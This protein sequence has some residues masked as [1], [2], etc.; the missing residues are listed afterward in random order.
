MESVGLSEVEEDVPGGESDEGEDAL[1]RGLGDGEGILDKASPRPKVRSM[2]QRMTSLRER[3][4]D[5]TLKTAESAKRRE[6]QRRETDAQR[7]R[8]VEDAVRERELQAAERRAQEDLRRKTAALNAQRAALAKKKK[9]PVP[10]K[11]AGEV[12]A[13]RKAAGESSDDYEMDE[14]SPTRQPAVGR[15]SRQRGSSSR[16]KRLVEPEYDADMEDDEP[17]PPKRPVAN[18][19]KTPPPRRP[20]REPEQ[21]AGELREDSD[22][23]EVAKS[24]KEK[25]V[26]RR[27]SLTE[28]LPTVPSARAEPKP[29]ARRGRPPKQ[30]PLLESAT[31]SPLK[32]RKHPDPTP[33][34]ASVKNKAG[35]VV[36]DVVIG[37]EDS[38]DPNDRMP[39][40]KRSPRRS[41]VAKGNRTGRTVAPVSAPKAKRVQ[42]NAN[43]SLKGG[44]K[45]EAKSDPATE[46][47]LEE[48]QAIDQLE[49]ENH[50]ALSKTAKQG[51]EK[52]VDGKEREPASSVRR[53]K[54][55]GVKRSESAMQQT[56]EEQLLKPHTEADVPTNDAV[57]GIPD[58]ERPTKRQKATPKSTPAGKTLA[59]KERQPPRT[60]VRSTEAGL[61]A[62]TA[63]APANPTDKT[64]ANQTNHAPAPNPG[65]GAGQGQKMLQK[66]SL[67]QRR[68]RASVIAPSSPAQNFADP[69][70]N[71][72]VPVNE[73]QQAVLSVAMLEAL[74]RAFMHFA[75]KQEQTVKGYLDALRQVSASSG[76]GATSSSN[77]WQSLEERD[78]L[79]RQKLSGIVD[80]ARLELRQ[81]QE[82]ALVDFAQKVSQ[83]LLSSRETDVTTLGDILK[84]DHPV[85]TQKRRKSAPIGSRRATMPAGS[86][87]NPTLPGVSAAASKRMPAPRVTA[88]FPVAAEVVGYTSPVVHKKVIAAKGKVQTTTM[89]PSK[90]LV[91]PVDAAS[92]P[93]G[94]QRKSTTANGVADVPRGHHV[95]QPPEEDASGDDMDDDEVPET[96]YKTYPTMTELKKFVGDKYAS[97]NMGCARS[98]AMLL[99][100]E[101]PG[102][103]R[104]ETLYEIVPSAKRTLK[105]KIDA[106]VD[107][108][109]LIETD[110]VDRDGNEFKV[111]TT[112][113]LLAPQK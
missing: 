75:A 46:A 94:D 52:S 107:N 22:A 105:T 85:L 49:T 53:N 68:T 80:A 91:K 3:K 88:Q 47:R 109:Y 113:N 18:F 82:K 23:M 42:S 6:A 56:Q 108:K 111:Y 31:A 28:E 76:S 39:L 104:L 27:K 90:A 40:V 92:A 2:A 34:A 59:E 7:R 101:R 43:D 26:A 41:A 78:N 24:V 11:G 67:P 77:P 48:S 13:P 60:A 33:A 20:R 110:L 99:L 69:A 15:V 9:E 102:G 10:R 100:C 61:K 70:L 95:N 74:Q 32:K 62:P 12:K 93:N 36:T 19:P 73:E 38:D 45:E 5:K 1:E 51:V 84:R 83:G 89:Q 44:L 4:T 21:Q 79:Q 25:E 30:R 96:E 29:K 71:E 54:P 58:E 55:A 106:L 35:T 14:V 81:T 37:V 72:A 97:L 8:A 63:V 16:G 66:G 98:V 57:K 17:T 86:S 50:E 112:S 87:R 103:M 65:G 64:T